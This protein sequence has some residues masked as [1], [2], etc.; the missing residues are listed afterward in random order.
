[1]TSC[2]LETINYVSPVE[3]QVAYLAGNLLN[4]EKGNLVSEQ[5]EHMAFHL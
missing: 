1:M 3:R 5:K 2:I 4:C